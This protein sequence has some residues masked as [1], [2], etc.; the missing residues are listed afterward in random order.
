MIFK[1][2]WI[3]CIFIFSIV[4]TSIPDKSSAIITYAEFGPVTIEGSNGEYLMVFKQYTI[5]N[6]V[7]VH[8][9]IKS[10]TMRRLPTEF[11]IEEINDT[12]IIEE[13]FDYNG[14][15][16]FINQTDVVV[17]D[18]TAYLLLATWDQ[19]SDNVTFFALTSENN[20]VSWSDP[21]LIYNTSVVYS[22]DTY[23]SF[24]AIEKDDYLVLG[25]GYK[26]E[27]NISGI[28]FEVAVA[29][30]LE[31]NAN[32]LI[33]TSNY[34]INSGYG[35]DFEFYNYNGDILV[36]YTDNP[37]I[38]GTVQFDELDDSYAIVSS[39]ATFSPPENRL[40][41]LKP[42]VTYWLGLF[43]VVAQDN[44]TDVVDAVQG[45]IKRESFLWGKSF[46]VTQGFFGLEVVENSIKN[47]VII[48]AQ[49]NFDGY[50]RRDPS[51][52]VYENRLFLTFIV[53][54]GSRFGGRGYPGVAFA[55]SADG[56]T[57]TNN[58]L[59]EY[60]FFMNL[61]TYFVIG[62]VAVFAVSYPSY[63]VY[64]KGIKGKK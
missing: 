45:T 10:R 41:L 19:T 33:V 29:D 5:S 31:I 50:Y 56:D 58:F 17:Q 60:S 2:K 57:W 7:S 49:D 6:E 54:R 1:K 20:G 47:R 14:R 24:D 59:G 21:I 38:A 53:G 40:K 26:A 44:L 43:Y 9:A 28:I 64:S 63:L 16:Y 55:F 34:T 25:Y 3:V 8:Q 48:K 61:G 30:V 22:D 27:V 36:I 4:L 15:T 18:G 62:T 37:G 39:I 12:E 11:Q 51:I 13:T 23:Y 52:T 46:K 32:T 42:T 35:L